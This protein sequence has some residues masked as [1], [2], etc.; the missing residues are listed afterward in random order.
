MESQQ[1]PFWKIYE[2][3]LVLS[4]WNTVKLNRYASIQERRS[5]SYS[6]FLA[7]VMSQ[8]ESF[9]H[10]GKS[11][12]FRV[13]KHQPLRDANEAPAAESFADAKFLVDQEDWE[14]S[15]ERSELFH[16]C[17]LLVQHDESPSTPALEDNQ[18]PPPQATTTAGMRSLLKLLLED[19]LPI[20]LKPLLVHYD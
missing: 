8:V 3:K 14:K 15:A 18:P 10:P 5:S 11:S 19:M 9:S 7:P 17:L 13:K 2:A 12:L 6:E 4:I 16:S 20:M 1:Q